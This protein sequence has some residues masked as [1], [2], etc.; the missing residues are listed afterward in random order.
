MMGGAGGGG[1]EPWGG[2]EVG[3]GEGTHAA[4]CCRV[5]AHTLG[6]LMCIAPEPL[7]LVIVTHHKVMPR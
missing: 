3:R 5:A 7:L 2:Q 1:G 6:C 4:M